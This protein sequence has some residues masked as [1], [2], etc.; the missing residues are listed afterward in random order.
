MKLSKHCR[1]LDY[2][3]EKK[4]GNIIEEDYIKEYYISDWD[5]PFADLQLYKLP[6]VVG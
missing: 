2:K 5:A 1:R 6:D 4:K 3:T